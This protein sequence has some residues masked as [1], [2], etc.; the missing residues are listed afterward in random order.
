MGSYSS[1]RSVLRKGLSF[2]LWSNVTL[3]C[4]WGLYLVGGKGKETGDTFFSSAFFL[5]YIWP[6]LEREKKK[7]KKLL[8]N[9]NL[10]GC[11]IWLSFSYTSVIDIFSP[12]CLDSFYRMSI[13]YLNIEILVVLHEII[14]FVDLVFIGLSFWPPSKKV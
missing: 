3:L 12:I 8:I 5:I 10:V 2:G 7:K 14:L 13:S 4:C 6:F 1:S 9:E 11:L